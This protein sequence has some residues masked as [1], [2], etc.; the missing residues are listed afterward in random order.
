MRLFVAIPIP[1]EIQ[2]IV[3][4]RVGIT[5][6]GVNWQTD[7]KMHV[8]LFFLGDQSSESKSDIINIL[9]QVLI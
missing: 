4:E 3:M 8:T 1:T 2:Q 7:S 6:K 5:K 9:N